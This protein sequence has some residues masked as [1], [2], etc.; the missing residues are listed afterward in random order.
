MINIKTLKQRITLLQYIE[1]TLKSVESININKR[2]SLKKKD[3]CFYDLDGVFQNLR[4]LVKKSKDNNNE[5]LLIMG[6]D[7][8]LCGSYN[9]SI[10]KF[11]KN[12][13]V[14]SHYKTVYIIGKKIKKLQLNHLN[15]IYSNYKD[16]FKNKMEELYDMYGF[17]VNILGYHSKILDY[18]S[19]E[20]SLEAIKGFNNGGYQFNDNFIMEGNIT[21]IVQSMMFE[22]LLMKIIYNIET[23]ENNQRLMFLK[24]AIDNCG[25]EINE[26][27]KIYRSLRQENITRE[28]N[29]LIATRCD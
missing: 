15:V 9:S 21:E 16:F 28:I 11:F 14:E 3:H 6:S 12:H 18:K 2:A 10:I 22:Y 13:N 26:N 25:N 19:L 20:E 29:E 23:Q 24:N 5:C 4:Y 7:N 27:I 1:K 8:S 17:N